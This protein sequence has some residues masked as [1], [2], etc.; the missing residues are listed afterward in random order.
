M[1]VELNGVNVELP[2]GVTTLRDVIESTRTEYHEG[3]VVGIVKGRRSQKLEIVK[4]YAIQTSKGEIKIEINDDTKLLWFEN[5]EKF[6]G[7]KVHWSQPLVASIGPV[8]TNLSVDR[9]EREYQRWDVVYSLGGFDNSNTYLSFVKRRHIASYGTH[10]AVGKT[11]AGKNVLEKLENGDVIQK[12]EPIEQWELVTDKFTTSDLDLK[13]DNGMEIYTYVKVELSRDASEGVEHFLALVKDGYF[14][15]DATT[16][17]YAL[18]SRLKGRSCPFEIRDVRS[19]GSVTIRTA[20]SSFGNV[21]IY[22]KDASS[23]PNHSVVGYVSEG[24]EFVK[25]A[26][27]GQQLKVVTDPV[28]IMFL[29]KKY[30]AVEQEMKKFDLEV[31]KIG[32]AGDDAIIVSQIP[33]NTVD[34]L[35]SKKVLTS[36]IP[37]NDLVKVELFDVTAPKTV[38]YFRTVTGLRDNPVGS[39]GV[40]VTYGKTIIF[41]SQTQEKFELV[42]ENLPVEIVKNGEIGV[43]NQAAKHAGLVG[44][45]LEDNNRYG[46]TGEKFSGTNIIGRVIEPRA[47]KDIKEGSMIYV[48]EAL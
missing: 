11:T 33:L 14:R 24:L 47:L 23:N 10:A 5:Y 9:N 15:V 17:S 13:L 48:Y 35:K 25:L 21:Y 41:R 45:R 6:I 36:A 2:Q 16:N 34:I 30:D 28:R 20:G 1:Y 26:S 40:Y 38:S 43:T 42:P 19:E 4:E 37:G 31:E 32:Y 39:L 29:G 46:P 7:S 12:I 8:V 27:A 22:K 18:S 3:L 44:V